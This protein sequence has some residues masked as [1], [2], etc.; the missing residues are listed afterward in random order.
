MA[1]RQDP[2]GPDADE[3]GPVPSSPTRS[4]PNRKAT[5]S[6]SGDIL[7]HSPVW[8]RAA[9]NG[10]ATY[11][12]EPMFGA[13]EPFVR[14]VDLSVCRLDRWS[15]AVQADLESVRIRCRQTDQVVAG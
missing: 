4:E 5:V 11:D 2:L 6:T 8:F 12:F 7:I 13:I 3:A 10:G 14:D 15:Q 1:S 9:A